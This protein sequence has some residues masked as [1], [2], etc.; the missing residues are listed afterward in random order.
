VR[1]EPHI[2]TDLL[3]LEDVIARQAV[4][5]LLVERVQEYTWRNGSPTSSTGD[6]GVRENGRTE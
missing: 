2:D 3:A 6:A 1:S 4:A 5:D